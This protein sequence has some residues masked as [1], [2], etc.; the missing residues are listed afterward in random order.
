[1]SYEKGM[2]S[3][4]WKAADANGDRLKYKVEIRGAGEREWM[5]LKEDVGENRISF[6]GSRFPDGRY[7]L[8][9]T[10]SDGADNYP[11]AALSAVAESGEFL[12]DNTAPVVTGLTARAEGSRVVVRFKA[13]DA[14]SPLMAAEYAVNGGEWRYAAPTTRITDSQ[15]HDYEAAF[16]KPAGGEIVIAVKVG[17]ENDNVAVLKTV[18]RP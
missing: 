3:A 8:R 14:L 11:E 1:M 4:R 9:V 5:V 7:R 6:D 18:V 16:E 13:A 12:I 2:V 10:A 15:E 17:D